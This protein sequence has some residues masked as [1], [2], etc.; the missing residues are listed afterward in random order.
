MKLVAVGNTEAGSDAGD[1]HADLPA[2]E[3][4]HV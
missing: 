3:S 1:E 4:R 2:V